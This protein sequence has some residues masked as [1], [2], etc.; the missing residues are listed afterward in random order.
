MNVELKF[1][2]SR[3]NNVTGPIKCHIRYHGFRAW[4]DLFTEL[5]LN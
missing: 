5:N 1:Y 4:M 2:S 3:W